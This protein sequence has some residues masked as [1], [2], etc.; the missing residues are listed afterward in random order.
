M[1]ISH[2]FIPT[3]AMTVLTGVLFVAGCNNA[4]QTGTSGA[5]EDMST[6]GT[7]AA[8]LGGA[9]AFS[10]SGGTFA[11]NDFSRRPS[12]LGPIEQILNSLP[13]AVAASNTCPTLKS[14]TGC[15]N[16]GANFNL[17]FGATGTSCSFAA[18]ATTP[19]PTWSGYMQTIAAGTTAACGTFPA[20]ANITT[21]SRQFTNSG[22]SAP[23]VG[24]R[25]AVSGTVVTIDDTNNNTAGTPTGSLGTNHFTANTTANAFGN[26]DGDVFPTTPI[27]GCTAGCS[28]VTFA[29]GV[30]TQISFLHHLS[31][32]GAFLE[33]DQTTF[34]GTLS[35]TPAITPTITPIAIATDSA[36]T[37]TITA[38][39]VTTFN[40][41]ANVYGVST[42]E[43]LVFN[44]QCCTPISG[45]IS[46]RFAAGQAAA[47]AL[48]AFY[49]TG[50]SETLTFSG[51]GTAVLT[52]TTG[53]A[54]QV[55]INHCF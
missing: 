24:S 51:C 53:T 23:G 2:L 11:L 55:N 3:A 41:L 12:R 42:L 13:S 48:T 32:N 6:S 31:A 20:V 43:N 38:G 46:T 25:T 49:V 21:F 22:F 17:T 26:F 39:T 36:G 7:V 28:Q 18:A 35:G 34:T 45:T 30:R 47:N 5:V 19:A 9:L 33:F 54:S 10:D 29:S 8:V 1:K 16:S 27:A 4:P 40:N 37:R 50:I 14:T 52:S 44:N 15:A